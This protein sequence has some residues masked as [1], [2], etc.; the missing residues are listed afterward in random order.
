MNSI[1]VERLQKLIEDE[2]RHQV[3]NYAQIIANR[4]DIS[5]K[6]LLRDVDLLFT[7]PGCSNRCR[8]ITTKKTQCLATGKHGGYCSRHQLQKKPPLITGKVVTEAKTTGVQPEE[9]IPPHHVG[10]SL[11]E[12]LYLPGCPACEQ[13]HKR[14]KLMIAL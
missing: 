3:N 1:L 6:L 10:H 13:L 12:T 14:P 2:V 4:H 11:Q 9:N 8:G 7:D 5:L